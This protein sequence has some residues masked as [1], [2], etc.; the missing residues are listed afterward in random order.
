MLQQYHLSCKYF[1]LKQKPWH[2]N[3]NNSW[4][5]SIPYPDKDE[6]VLYLEYDNKYLV[7]CRYV[8]Q[9]SALQQIID[10]T[11]LEIVHSDVDQ[12]IRI[13]I[14]FERPYT[15]VEEDTGSQIG[16]KEL[17]RQMKGLAP[18]GSDSEITYNMD[19]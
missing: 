14:E 16:S 13:R 6:D 18:T 8:D 5:G 9:Y 4:G 3:I 19:P 10:I 17:W 15:K 2:G 7:K 12:I 11:A 1:L